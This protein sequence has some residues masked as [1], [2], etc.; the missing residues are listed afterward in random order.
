MNL[1][2]LLPVSITAIIAT[3]LSMPLAGASVI[4]YTAAGVFNYSQVPTSITIGDKFTLTFDVDTSEVNAGSGQNGA[5]MNAVQNLSFSLDSGSTGTYAGGTMT[6][7]QF[8]QLTDNWYGFD[9]INFYASSAFLQ[10]G[11]DFASAG[12]NPF[13]EFDINLYSS[14]PNTFSLS[15]GSGQTLDSVL[16]ALNLA[17]YDNNASVGLV[18]GDW[19]NP[20]WAYA[21]ITSIT[22]QSA[23]SVP[24]CGVTIAMLGGA[25]LSLA[26]V[27]RRIAG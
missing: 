4:Q 21:N 13:V 24:D 10:T 18:F 27:R 6:S 1:T 3:I 7:S 26:A 5:F 11:L 14:N 9:T 2:R 23:S 22:N 8:L 20:L 17:S 25:L 15:G 16:P 19:N 12:S